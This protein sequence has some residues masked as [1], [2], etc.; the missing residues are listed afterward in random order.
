[1]TGVRSCGTLSLKEMGSY[2]RILSR[3]LAWSDL[4]FKRV[5]LPVV[6]E[7]D[8]RGAKVKAERPFERVQLSKQVVLV[9]HVVVTVTVVRSAWILNIV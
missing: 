6:I 7:A 2:C 3:R 1:M 5:P 9:A 8:V 4:Y